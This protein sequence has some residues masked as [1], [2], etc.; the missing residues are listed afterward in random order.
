MKWKNSEMFDW[1]WP[2][3]LLIATKWYEGVRCVCFTLIYSFLVTYGEPYG[4]IVMCWFL[5]IK[6][7]M[8]KSLW[9]F[10][11]CL[12]WTFHIFYHEVKL[13][14]PLFFGC[15]LNAGFDGLCWLDILTFMEIVWDW[16]WKTCFSFWVS[17]QIGRYFSKFQPKSIKYRLTM[18]FL[19]RNH[20]ECLSTFDYSFP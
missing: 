5:L 7:K 13:I 18:N 1:F 6:R 10:D 11:R 12:N 20:F 15:C 17:I 4:K 19:C 16:F 2:A 3:C 14:F 8:C 9:M